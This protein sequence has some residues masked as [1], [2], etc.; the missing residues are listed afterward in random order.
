MRHRIPI[1]FCLALVAA[2]AT[3]KDAVLTRTLAG[4]DAAHVSFVSLDEQRQAEIVE[5]A[6]TLD[7]GKAALAAHRKARNKITD[8]FVAAYGAVAVAAL[9]PSDANMA[10]L[11]A[12][13]V[14]AVTALKGWTP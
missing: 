2:C 12:L 13:A 3:S 5:H 4:L 6:S 1:L 11:V 10:R 9:E 14:A 8:A 7:E